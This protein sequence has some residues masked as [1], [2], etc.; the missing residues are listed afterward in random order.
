MLFKRQKRSQR[1]SCLRDLRTI[2]TMA[3]THAGNLCACRVKQE[4]DLGLHPLGDFWPLLQSYIRTQVPTFLR[5]QCQLSVS[6]IGV[7]TIRDAEP[8]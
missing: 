6:F 5:H 1:C 8:P 7:C 4:L 3:V 2:D